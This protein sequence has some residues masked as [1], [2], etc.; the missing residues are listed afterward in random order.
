MKNGKDEWEYGLRNG[1]W[2]IRNG[3]WTKGNG[4]AMANSRCDHFA[5]GFTTLNRNT[6]YHINLGRPGKST[7]VH[8]WLHSV[9]YLSFLGVK[10]IKDRIN[11]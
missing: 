11:V 4:W 5:F 2:G 3:Q 8:S 7:C 6:P 1:E 9:V 10:G